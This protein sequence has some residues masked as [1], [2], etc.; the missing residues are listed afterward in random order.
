MLW[1]GVRVHVQG[2]QH[3]RSA[4]DAGYRYP[5]TGPQWVGNTAVLPVVFVVDDSKLPACFWQRQQCQE[6]DAKAKS[7]FQRHRVRRLPSHMLMFHCLQFVMLVLAQ[8]ASALK[9]APAGHDPAC[10][11]PAGHGRHDRRQTSLLHRQGHSGHQVHDKEVMRAARSHHRHCLYGEWFLLLHR[12]GH[13]GHRVQFVGTNMA[14][15]QTRL[16]RRP[17]PT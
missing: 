5:I 9:P 14:M 16:V 13:S 8:R 11:D 1:P 15:H 3:V 2:K 17:D 4:R 12:H 6:T 7:E 10:H